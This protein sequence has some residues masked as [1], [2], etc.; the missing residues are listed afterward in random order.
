MNI[1]SKYPAKTDN[2]INTT[3]DSHCINGDDNIS[4]PATKLPQ[5]NSITT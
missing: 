4:H 5:G 1:D 3:P 2:K